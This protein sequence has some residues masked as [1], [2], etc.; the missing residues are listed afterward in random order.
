MR[1]HSQQWEIEQLPNTRGKMVLLKIL[2]TPKPDFTQLQKAADEYDRL[3]DEADR[4]EA[5]KAEEKTDGK[6]SD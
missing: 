4:L 2:H 6:V 5:L 3:R 1:I